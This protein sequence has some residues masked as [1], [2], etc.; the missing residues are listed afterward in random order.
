[1]G[2][3][4][5]L[6]LVG[7]TG[8]VGSELIEVLGERRFPV[9]EL[10]AFASEESE[11]DSVELLGATYSVE[12]LSD[13]RVAPCDLIFG[14]A[15]VF[16]D[17]LP[18]LVGSATRVVDLSGALEL[19]HDV[20]LYLAGFRPELPA[21]G[22]APW[23][24]VPRGVAAGLGLT[25]GPLSRVAEIRRITV[26][27]LESASGA[28]RV[29]ADALSEQTIEVL[30]A[31]AGDSEEEPSVFPQA[32]AFD[33]LP[34]VGEL[35]EGG[36]SAEERR[37][38]HVLR[39]ILEAPSLPIEVTRVRVPIFSGS[40]SLVHVE[41]AKDVSPEQAREVWHAAEG[42]QVLDPDELPTPR[43]ALAEADLV[44]VG[45]IRRG[46]AETNGLAFVVGLDDLRR[47]AALGAV[48]AAEALVA[49]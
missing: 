28:G 36:E 31:M 48:L 30:N 19:E 10:R 43:G 25:L 40:L 21:P 46:G 6:G 2:S 4:Y 22:H 47:G 12:R 13:A 45:R 24:A 20:P 9:A 42:V 1:M 38:R 14:A 26:T 39:R 49:S 18:K 37:L 17:L 7:A 27:T 44:A 35:L 23:V 11:G 5:R 29:G 3:G 33:C 16:G 34:L 32:L 8:A 41:L 15:P